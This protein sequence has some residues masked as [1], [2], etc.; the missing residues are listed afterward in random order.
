MNRAPHRDTIAAVA[1]PPGT[2]GIAIVRVSGPR[3]EAVLKSLFHRADRRAAW[4]SHVMAY[5]HLVHAG[6]VLDEAMGVLMRAPRSFTCEDVAELHCHGGPVVTARV[7]EAALAC[8]A[9]AAEPGEFSRRAFEAG[10]IDLAQA[11]ATMELIGASG[12]QAPRAAVRQLGGGL[13]RAVRLAQQELVDLLAALEAATDFP[14]EVDEVLTARQVREAAAALARRLRDAC[15]ARAG[16]VLERGL[17][18]TIAGQPNVGKSSLLN[19]LLEEERAIVTDI[20]G[21]TRDVLTG[22]IELDGLRVNLSD[23]AGLRDSKDPVEALGVARARERMDQADLVL[24]VLDASRPLSEADAALIAGLPP[25]RTAVL[26]NKTDLGELLT[27]ERIHAV[28][29]DMPCRSLSVRTAQGLEAV[30]ALLRAHAGD[31]RGEHA[32]LVAARHVEAAQTAVRALEAACQTL[33]EA[34]PVDLAVIDLR[35]ALHALGSITGEDADE[36]VIDAV[37]ANFCVGK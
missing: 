27:P 16:R 3:A 13:S 10:R 1:T 31:I 33:G 24:V 15:D 30:K 21:T 23:T 29:P 34:M 11:E 36:R 9:R 20:P 12:T 17:D 19:L 32:L 28:A 26:L 2:G 22:S 6:E 8:G 35:A 7:L 14:D 18:V 25:E 4:E 37:F 5:G